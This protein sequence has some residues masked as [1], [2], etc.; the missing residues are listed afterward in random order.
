MNQIM[1]SFFP[2][3]AAPGAEAEGN[4]NCLDLQR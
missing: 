4:K 3:F 2:T 1:M